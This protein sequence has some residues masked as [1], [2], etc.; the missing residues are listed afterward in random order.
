VP[1][2]GLP[3]LAG[4]PFTD[5]FAQL[6]A[7]KL[8]VNVVFLGEGDDQTVDHT[9]PAAGTVVKG[10]STVKLFVKGSAPLVTVPDLTGLS[11]ASG[12]GTAGNTLFEKG[13]KIAYADGVRDGIVI[14]QT[15]DATS[16]TTHW[17]DTVTVT[18][19]TASPTDQPSAAAG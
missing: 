19:G 3:N 14:S 12:T 5:A 4:I 11:C 1:G 18:C 6:R 7:L 16:T 10:G 15:P 8:G 2:G 13:L 9:D 17:N